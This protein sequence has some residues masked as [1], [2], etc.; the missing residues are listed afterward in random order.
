MKCRHFGVC[1]GCTL[2]GVPY[3]EQL[4]KKRQDLARLLRLDVPPLIPS[5]SEAGFRCKVAFVFGT[6]RAGGLMMGHYALESQRIV[7]IEECPVHHER[8]NRIAF[9]LR[10]QP[11]QSRGGRS[12]IASRH[13][14]HH[15]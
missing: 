11:L 10:D 5:P 4:A 12:L 2:P 13:H 6:L 15:R 1:G 9:A 7:P 14:P 3:N 8:G